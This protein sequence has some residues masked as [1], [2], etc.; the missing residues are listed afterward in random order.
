MLKPK[1]TH[2]R[3]GKAYLPIFSCSL[4]RAVH[5][6]LVPNLETSTLILCLKRL[7]ARRGRPTVIYS[8]NGSMFV[9]AAKWF[10]QV[11][12]DKQLGFLE[13]HDIKWKFNLSHAPWCGAQF[14][15]LI[16]IVKKVIHKVSGRATLSWNELTEV[17]LDVE[18]QVNR[19]PLGYIEDNIELPSLTPASFMFQ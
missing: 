6:E 15:C 2:K 11:T 3:G 14:E 9:K 5:L 8:D 18:T 16:G 19:R 7:I 4:L 10:E 12:R 1:L 13:S 17:L